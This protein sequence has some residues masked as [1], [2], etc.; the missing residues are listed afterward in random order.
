MKNFYPTQ[1]KNDE[2]YFI[3]HN[4]LK[5]QF[6]DYEAIMKEIQEVILNTDFTLGRAVDEVEALIANEANTKFAIAVGSGTD[7][8]FLSLKAL[9]IGAGDEVITTHILFMQQLGLL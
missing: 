9:G 3:N 7:A 8:L 6:K 1:Y 2:K 5:D 4:Y